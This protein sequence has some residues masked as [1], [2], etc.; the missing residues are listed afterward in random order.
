MTTSPP[1]QPKSGFDWSKVRWGGPRQRRTTRCSYC[2]NPLDEET[3][4]LILWK[5]DGSA[6]EFCDACQETWWGFALSDPF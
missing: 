6:A 5:S 2:S 1:L 4:P 3:V